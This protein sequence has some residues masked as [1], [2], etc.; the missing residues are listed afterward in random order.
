MNSLSSFLH[1]LHVLV[2]FA[3]TSVVLYYSL[4]AYRRTKMRAF[5]LWV[6][7]SAIGI[8]QL[9]AYESYY[10]SGPHSFT[11]DQRAT[12]IWRAGYILAVVLSSVGSILLIRYV[13]ARGADKNAG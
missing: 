6:W 10:S 3:L 5:A 9:L 4:V 13:L 12:L 7:A 8:V 2:S 11:A 1:V